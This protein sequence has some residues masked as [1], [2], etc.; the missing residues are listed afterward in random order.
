MELSNYTVLCAMIPPGGGRQNIS[1]RFSR[2]FNL[3][4]IESFDDDLIRSIFQPIMNWYFNTSG[5]ASEYT[6][7]STVSSTY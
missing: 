7:F 6:K 5:F 2:H 4:S 3:L 1:N